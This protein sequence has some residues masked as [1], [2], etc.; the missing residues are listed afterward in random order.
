MECIER[1]KGTKARANRSSHVVGRARPRN[2]TRRRGGPSWRWCGDVC[3]DEAYSRTHGKVTAVDHPA[4]V[5]A[6]S[7]TQLQLIRTMVRSMY[8][9]RSQHKGGMFAKKDLEVTLP[10][11]LVLGKWDGCQIWS[12]GETQSRSATAPCMLARLFATTPATTTPTS[13]CRPSRCHLSSQR[14]VSS[15]NRAARRDRGSRSVLQRLGI[16]RIPA[17][18]GLDAA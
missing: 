9:D 11:T 17:E 4:R 6:P 18:R 15:S 14:G 2:T 12:G 1:K 10:V 13:A 16:I 3:G 5:V 8:D 7:M